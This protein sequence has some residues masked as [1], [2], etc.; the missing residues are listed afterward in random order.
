MFQIKYL[1]ATH[2]YGW[3]AEQLSYYISF[4]GAGRALWLLCGLPGMSF[5]VLTRIDV[6]NVKSYLALIGFFKPKPVV[7]KTEENAS[8]ATPNATSATAQGTALAKGKKPKPT[9]AQLGQE[10]SFDLIL[11]RCSVLIDVV[12][13]SLVALFPAPSYT[14]HMQSAL[15]ALAT[16]G[17]GGFNRSQALFVFSTSLNGMGSG[18]V[19]AMHSLALCMLQVRR[20]N[21]QT[22]SGAGNEKN[23]EGT[24]ALFGALAVVQAIGQMILGVSIFRYIRA[25]SD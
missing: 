1:Y 10:I 7:P 3:G 14:A 6:T 24:G 4:M 23:E 20:L 9:R 18:S 11:T 13:H 2:T 15:S 12:S 5:L 22:T 8:T 21:G 16:P 25:A 17:D 19:P